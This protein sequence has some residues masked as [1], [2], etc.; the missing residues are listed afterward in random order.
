MEKNH[1]LIYLDKLSASF[2]EGV[3]LKS[4]LCFDKIDLNYL[5]NK[6]KIYKAYLYLKNLRNKY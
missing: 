4:Y 1:I 2:V 5:K 3:L 6:I